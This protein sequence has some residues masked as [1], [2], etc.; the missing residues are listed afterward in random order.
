LFLGT[1]IYK[2]SAR[3]GEAQKEL[4]D[5][6]NRLDEAKAEQ[7]KFQSDLD[8]YSNPA[9]LEKE[10]RARFNYKTIGESLIIIVPGNATSAT[11]SAKTGQ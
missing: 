1:Q 5:L 6:K 4:T 3:G 8:Y 9:N 10:L 11:S 7:A 2:F